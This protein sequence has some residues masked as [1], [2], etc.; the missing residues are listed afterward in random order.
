MALIDGDDFV[1]G[2][3]DSFQQNN[4]MKN[5]W[6]QADPVA[7]LGNPQPGMIVSDSDD[8]KLYHYQ[9]VAY[10]EIIQTG[11]PI[12]DDAQI[13]GGDGSDA[14]LI[15]YEETTNDA[16]IWGIPTDPKRGI[17]FCDVADVGANFT[18]LTTAMDVCLRIVD[19]DVDSILHVG[20]VDDDIPHIDSNR[21]IRIQYEA[22]NDVTFFQNCGAGENRYVTIYGWSTGRGARQFTRFQMSDIN[23]E[24]L[25]E[26][27]NN[28]DHEGI[29]IKFNEAGQRFR[30]RQGGDILSWYL[31]GTDAF[32]KWSDGQLEFQTDEVDATTVLRIKPNGTSEVSQLDFY[33]TD[34]I[35]LSLYTAADRA[36]ILSTGGVLGINPDAAQDVY[37]FEDAASGETPEI[38]IYGF[39]AADAKRSL[40]IGVGVDAA[41]TASFDGVSNYY[42]DGN[43]G[44]G[45]PTPDYNL[46][47][48]SA[49]TPY[50][51]VTDT[52]TPVKIAIIAD[53]DFGY[54]GTITN[55]SLQFLINGGLEMTLNTLGN[56]GLGTQTFG[57][58]ANTVYAQFNGIA[59]TTS[60][61]DTFQMW[62]ADVLAVAG[63]AGP[64]QR[65]EEGGMRAWHGGAGTINSFTYQA[66]VGDDGI[67]TL[68]AITDA[69]WGF[70][71][72]GD[73]EEYALFTIDNDGDVTLI[74]NSA[75]VVANTDVDG[76]ICLGTAG[77]QEPLQVRNRLGAQKNINLIIWYS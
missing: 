38:K 33:D 52:T 49:S 57:T 32:M 10:E 1:S 16:V 48:E 46:E 65:S 13:I 23:D 40:E 35:R 75:N 29:T 39:R 8:E 5:H 17:I 62:S 2:D 18:G 53:N 77:S 56:L 4:R 20:F 59:P 27:E 51:V 21:D 73:N 19:K 34:G 66:D 55:H 60:P 42:F 41:D 37:I 9:A 12:T 7:N 50:L 15:P 54:I 22:Q 61:A 6:R 68:P 14:I 28:A 30:I 31:D 11:T 26:A 74:S 58:N 25:I 64:H 36:Y 71:Q 69:A 67:F 63:K 44:V 3:L 70:I 47:V 24:F 72:A 45:T 43:V 76:K